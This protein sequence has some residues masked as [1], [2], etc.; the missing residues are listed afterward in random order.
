MD[1]NISQTFGVYQIKNLLDGK[2]Y[3]GST[4]KSFTHRWKQWHQNIKRGKANRHLQNAWNKHG[5]ENFEFSILEIVEDATQVLDREQH[6][7]D[8]LQSYMPCNG[9][10]FR[11]EARSDRAG[12]TCSEETRRKMSERMMGNTYTL[13]HKASDEHR[14]KNRLA[15]IGTQPCLGYKHTEEARANMSKALMGNKNTLGHKLTEEHKRK[16]AETSR[17]RLHTEETKRKMSEIAKERGVSDECREAAR[18]ANTGKPSWNKGKPMSDDAKA[19]LSASTMGENHHGYGKP[20]SEET[21]R[22][23]SETKRRKRSEPT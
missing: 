6:W 13:G 23:I 20:M 14:E 16:V 7:L 1:I 18:K 12:T 10:N 22:K 17:G 15:H 9:Y 4:S 21:K 3:V 2:V 5:A 19:K 11:R 8:H